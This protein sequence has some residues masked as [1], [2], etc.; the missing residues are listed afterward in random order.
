[1]KKIDLHP[2]KAKKKFPIK[3]MY[4]GWEITIDLG[5]SC[6]T[7]IG[8]KLKNNNTVNTV[9]AITKSYKREEDLKD[10]VKKFKLILEQDNTRNLK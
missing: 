10:C 2:T 1:M 5:L 3:L 6:Y 7:F 9:I 4:K 8:T